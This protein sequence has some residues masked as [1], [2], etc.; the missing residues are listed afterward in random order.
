[1]SARLMKRLGD[2]PQRTVLMA[3]A[4]VLVL[5][6]L[7]GWLLVLRQPWAEH[8]RLRQANAAVAARPAER[9]SLRSEADRMQAELAAMSTRLLALGS[10]RRPDEAIAE[11]A[12]SLARLAA[13]RDVTLSG[14]QPG[15]AQRLPEFEE[16]P[17][18][19]RLSG[20]YQA[21]AAWLGVVERELGPLM[22]T[23]F[24]IRTAGDA[25]E[26]LQLQL[27]LALYRPVDPVEK[28]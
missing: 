16:L 18:E 26:R 17:I 25:S 1:M 5:V 11:V 14:L 23:R 4:G 9:A 10:Q 20:R 3:M 13:A 2:L 15:V 24:S 27:Q 19:L 7:E 28:K 8:A 12:E 6:A 22:I 21:L